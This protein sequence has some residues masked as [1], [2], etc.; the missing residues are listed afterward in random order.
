M[1]KRCYICG[2]HI[3]WVDGGSQ[4]EITSGHCSFDQKLIDRRRSYQDKLRET[5][6][7]ILKLEVDKKLCEYKIALFSMIMLRR[8]ARMKTGR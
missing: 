1:E 8:E 4:F 7:K 2:N 5:K 6:E 3:E